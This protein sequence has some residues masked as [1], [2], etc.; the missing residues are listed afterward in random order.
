MDL[1]IFF[2]IPIAVIVF[3][4][5]LQRSINC[6]TFVA[7]IIFSILLI[8]TFAVF[9]ITFLVITIIYTILSF[10]TAVIFKFICC[11]SGNNMQCS[12]NCGCSGSTGENSNDNMINDINSIFNNSVNTINRIPVNSSD[13]VVRNNIARN[14]NNY[15]CCVRRRRI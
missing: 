10:V 1:L 5:V 15:S 7:A 11:L 9:D 8:V 14:S 3:S 13:N 2:A 4:I 12:S 6:P